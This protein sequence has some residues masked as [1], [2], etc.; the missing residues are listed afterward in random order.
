ML[1]TIQF[2]VVL[3]RLSTFGPLHLGTRMGDETE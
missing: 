3:G 2:R 1:S